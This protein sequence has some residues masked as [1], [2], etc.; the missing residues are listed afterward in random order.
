MMACFLFSFIDMSKSTSPL[1]Y[2]VNLVKKLDYESYIAT[3]FYPRHARSAAFTLRAFNLE[4]AQ[5][6]HASRDRKVA[7]ARLHFWMNVCLFSP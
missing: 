1:I 2:C 6:Y 5:A 4:L 3:M 7:S